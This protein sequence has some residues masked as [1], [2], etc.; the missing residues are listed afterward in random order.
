MTLIAPLF[1]DDARFGR[2][3]ILTKYE[4]IDEKNVANA[5]AAALPVHKKN[6]AA[7]ERLYLYYLGI[8][9]ILDKIKEYR[10][11]VNN[12]VGVA[13]ATE[14]VSFFSGYIMGAPIAYT[15]HDDTL[16]EDVARRIS[17]LNDWCRL[18]GKNKCDLELIF[19][20]LLCG[21]A[22]R[23]IAPE[24][25]YPDETPFTVYALDP[26]KTFVA[27]S[28]RDGKTPVFAVDTNTDEDDNT[29]YTV[30]TH[31]F[32]FDIANN[33]VVQSNT[34]ALKLIPIVE[35]PANS[36]RIGVFEPVIPLLNAIETIQSSR[37]DAV[38]QDVDNV[39]AIIGTDTGDPNDST[40]V[41]S[42]LQKLKMLVLPPGCDAKYI[43]A[44]LKQSDIQTVED[45]TRQ[46]VLTITGI[47]NRNGG[48]STS[49]TGKATELRDGWAAAEQ[50]AKTLAGFF[51]EA[52]IQ[53]LRVAN[54]IAAM[55]GEETAAVRD[56][57][58]AFPQRYTDNVLVRVQALQ[59]LLQTGVAP[60]DAFPMCQLVSDPNA[61]AIRNRERI[62]R[63]VF[64]RE[65]EN[66]GAENADPE[67][68]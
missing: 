55:Q 60:E 47:P 64:K 65:D 41:A 48:S 57:N 25:Q 21:T 43:T 28:R 4:S 24:R 6:E 7:I 19:W 35:Y 2:D 1:A 11:E 37:V 63:I 5:L 68:V 59:G 56:I 50:R 15:R 16:S 38:V 58:V 8:T 46:L 36:M 3:K 27:Y 53:F 34:N 13:M 62:D 22:Y 40:S 49:D 18:A 10:K 31:D 12:K 14:I 67:T 66:A 39:L 51:E 20:T 29:V 9:P 44:P 33:A 30:Y 23:C 26:R 17:A 52:E 61:V 54:K 42:M 32:V 45:S